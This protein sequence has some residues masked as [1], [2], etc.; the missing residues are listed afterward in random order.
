M[1]TTYGIS[2]QA[3]RYDAMSKLQKKEGLDK[4]KNKVYGEKVKKSSEDNLSSK[5]KS[6]LENLR[7]QYG[8][9]DF[10]IADG[11]DDRR[12]L[13]N[14]SDKE[15]SVIL[16]TE[17]IEKMASDE[18]YAEEKMNKVKTI[19]DMSDRICEQFGFE[20][21]WENGGESDTIL[22]KLAVSVN[23]DGSMTIFAQLEQMTE[24]QKEHIADIKEKRAEEKKELDNLDKNKVDL[25]RKKEEP[26]VKKVF[27][28]ASSEEE[29]I[30]KISNIDWNKAAGEKLGVRFDFSI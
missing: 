2:S 4:E 5:A 19:V 8:D 27:L 25:Y 15:Y 14:K 24:K 28:E 26:L 30:E 13:L 20:R 7:K 9:Y 3:S 16:S 17:E 1:I 29:L 12:G 10:I 22:N 6:Y 23:D 18:K 11:S 21:A